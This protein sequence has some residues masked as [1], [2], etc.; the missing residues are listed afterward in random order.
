MWNEITN[1]NDVNDFMNLFGGFHDSCIKEFKYISG[2]YIDED[3]SMY[4]I[5]DKRIFSIII[6]RQ[7]S[8]PS[9]IEMEYSGLLRLSVNPVDENYT[10]EILDATMILK[11]NYVYWYDSVKLSEGE[12]CNYNGVLICALRVRWRVAEEYIGQ[13]EIYAR[14]KD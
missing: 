7:Y 14:Q 2:A 1:Q 10:C 8:N 3:L 4:P 12:L 9:V 6:Q 11:E 13:S 5:N